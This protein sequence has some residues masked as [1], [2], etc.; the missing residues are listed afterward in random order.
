M[1]EA[2]ITLREISELGKLVVVV[3]AKLFDVLLWLIS[4]LALLMLIVGMITFLDRWGTHRRL[5]LALEEDYLVASA[6]ISWCYQDGGYCYTDFTDE[7][8]RE[9]YGKLDWRFYSKA[10]RA[11]L[12]EL[13]RGQTVLVRYA[14]DEFEDDLVLAEHY[15]AFLHYRGYIYDTVGL[16]LASWLILIR[17][18]EV[19]LLA[20]VDD[21]GPRVDEKWKRMTD[22]P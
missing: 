7:Q 14:S 2:L 10:V 5:R 20:L 9:R 19:M 15:H 18:P 1:D 13:D 12:S 17:H 22:L 3:A 21:L 16:A 4:P 8:G 6:T 11:E